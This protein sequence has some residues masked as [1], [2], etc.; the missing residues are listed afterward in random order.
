M[1]ALTATLLALLAGSN[2]SAMD[3]E[4]Q[5]EFSDPD[6]VAEVKKA[7]QSNLENA[8][9]KGMEGAAVDAENIIILML[10]ARAD[11]R[12]AARDLRGLPDL[13]EGPLSGGTVSA[14]TVAQSFLE[15]AVALDARM[16]EFRKRAATLKL[17]P[18]KLDLDKALTQR[19]GYRARDREGDL[20]KNRKFLSEAAKDIQGIR[21]ED[22]RLAAVQSAEVYL[23]DLRSVEGRLRGLLAKLQAGSKEK[24]DFA[25]AAKRLEPRI[26]AVTKDASDLKLER[27]L[28]ETSLLLAQH[29]DAA[30]DQGK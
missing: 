29:D 9:A 3:L 7:E 23:T 4:G 5:D 6:V 2:A 15:T 8:M 28:L 18:K 16:T 27:D 1:N 25:A 21:L 17:E 11:L 24:P 19:Q 10:S 12:A 26:A 14:A 30:F 22:E 20:A 13:E